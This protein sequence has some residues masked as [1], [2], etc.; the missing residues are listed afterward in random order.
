MK[1]CEEILAFGRQD[2]L[3]VRGAVKHL[4]IELLRDI[5]HRGDLVRPCAV[6]DDQAVGIRLVV[7]VREEPY[8]L[9]KAALDLDK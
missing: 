4:N 3:L 5:I 2:T 6:V 1:H 9:D 8:S 7:L